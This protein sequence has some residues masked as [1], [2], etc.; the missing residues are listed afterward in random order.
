MESDLNAVE[1]FSFLGLH[2]D[3]SIY[4]DPTTRLP[5]QVSGI[6]PSLGK[7]ELKLNEIKWGP[8]SD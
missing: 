4:I 2:Q 5:I 6:I 1:N 7:A 8:K 3:I